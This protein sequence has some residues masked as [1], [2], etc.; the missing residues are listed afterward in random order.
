M[1]RIASEDGDHSLEF[2]EEFRIPIGFAEIAAQTWIPRDAGAAIVFAYTGATPEVESFVFDLSRKLLR[3]EI[4]TVL[5]DLMPEQFKYDDYGTALRRYLPS[6]LRNRL[7]GTLRGIRSRSPL[8]A[9][10]MGCLG[11]GTCAAPALAAAADQHREPG[12]VITVGGRPELASEFVDELSAPTLLI[13]PWA[14]LEEDAALEDRLSEM[15]TGVTS[16]VRIHPSEPPFGDRTV[17][18][19]ATTLTRLW[20]RNRLVQK[21]APP[22]DF[23]DPTASPHYGLPPTPALAGAR[24][25]GGAV[26]A[27]V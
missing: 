15:L 24:R 8:E 11:V 6:L 27:R 19:R 20:F 5:V 3:E 21:A 22:P 1:Q 9:L 23:D 13:R 12:A 2:V 4:G 10:S 26:R 14:R 16:E 7:S 25:S 18:D 17:L